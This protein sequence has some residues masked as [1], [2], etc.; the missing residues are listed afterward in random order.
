MD[1]VR[2]SLRRLSSTLRRNPL[3]TNTAELGALQLVGYLLPLVSMPYLVRVLGTANY[4][5]YA[6]VLA[7]VGYFGVFA[8]F[9][10]GYTAVRGV[11]ESRQ[12]HDALGGVASTFT[13][14]KL[15]FGLLA[16]AGMNICSYALPLS[17][18][19]A[20]LTRLASP[21]LLFGSLNPAWYF[22]GLQR[23]RP[24]VVWQISVRIGGL[25]LLF[26]WVRGRHDL[27]AAIMVELVAAF[28]SM[29][30]GWLLVHRM[31]PMRLRAPTLK[32][33]GD[34]IRES[35][36]LFAS[37]LAG[38]MYTHALPLVLGATASREQMAYFAIAERI[39][40]AGKRLLSPFL[41]ALIPHI[42][43]LRA[44]DPNAALALLRRLFRKAVAAGGVAT[45]LVAL[46]APLLVWIASGRLLVHA[47]AT[48]ILMSPQALL[49]AVSNILGVQA[50]FSFSIV[51]PVVKVQAFVGAAA[52]VT[53][54]L[55]ATRFGAIGVA[56]VGTV[57]EA[58]IVLLFYRL[59]RAHLDF[60]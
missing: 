9:G 1:H 32:Q 59:S 49:I 40:N 36:Q 47:I 60:P 31:A 14:A 8:D 30:G 22:Q 6:L 18:D 57:A 41:Q 38:L 4:G 37:S 27:G 3:W 45:L 48:L 11:S 54:Y 19:L 16:F 29:G 28:A 20:G 51:R 42:N 24:L 43:Q 12:R 15:L 44:T 7:I 26:A 25:V 55:A 21:L 58:T 52:L 56:F 46:L 2:E 5:L 17:R 23:L 50:L 34:A 39:S 33:L 35:A 10:F 13:I 53:A